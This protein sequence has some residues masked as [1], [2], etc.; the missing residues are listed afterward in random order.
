MTIDNNYNAKIVGKLY[1]WCT[2]I[3]KISPLVTIDKFLSPSR[4]RRLKN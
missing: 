2:M 4:G 1:P 3:N